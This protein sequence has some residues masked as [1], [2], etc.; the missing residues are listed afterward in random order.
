MGYFLSIVKIDPNFIKYNLKFKNEIQKYA[1]LLKYVLIRFI[2]FRPQPPVLMPFH[3]MSY[4]YYIF[5]IFPIFHLKQI[6]M[7]SESMQ[8]I[9]YAVHFTANFPC[10]YFRLISNLLS[11]ILAYLLYE[12][13]NPNL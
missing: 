3:K 6:Y 8:N 5:V 7:K 13:K 9:I 11:Y 1:S 4:I 10:R 12:L 2:Y